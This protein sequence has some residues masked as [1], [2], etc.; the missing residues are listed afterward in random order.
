M[1][2]DLNNSVQDEQFGENTKNVKK[3]TLNEASGES[4]EAAAKKDE[5]LLEEENQLINSDE[6]VQKTK[7]AVTKKT[8]ASDKKLSEEEIPADSK[9]KADSDKDEVDS[10]EKELVESDDANAGADSSSQNTIEEINYSLLSKSDL[11]K[12]LDELVNGPKVNKISKEVEEIKAQF[13]K[14]HKAD[15][16]EKKKHFLESGGNETDF[17]PGINEDEL[18]L[19]EILNKYKD[20]RYQ[21]EQIHESEKVENLKKKYEIIEKIKELVHN[22]ESINKTFK[23]FSDLQKEWH[24]VG[25]VPQKDLKTLWENYNYHVEKFYDYIKI[26][27]ELRD[28][29]LKKNLEAKIV[30][31]E[32][33]EELILETN[34]VNAFHSLQKLHDQ[35]REI[36]PVDKEQR[37]EI[38]DRFKEATSKINKKHH[39]YYQDLKDQQKKNLESKIILC[40]KVEEILAENI[41]EHSLWVKKTKEILE[42]QNVWKTIGFAPKKDNNKVYARF[43]SAC[44]T[45][46]EKKRKF[47]SENMSNQTDNLNKKL[48]LCESAE[49][50]KDSE[51]WK[52]TADQ[53]IEIQKE[54]KKIGPVPRKQSDEVWKRFRAAC[55]HF[56]NKRSEFYANS[57]KNY[58]NNLKEKE[59]LIDEINAYIP[60]DNQKVNLNELKDFQRRWTEIGFVPINA[61]EEIS[62]KYREAIDRQFDKLDLDDHKKNM[63]KFKN[64]LEN[65]VQKPRS[66]NKLRFEREKMMTRLQQ[67]KSDISVWE[68]NI[69]FFANTKKADIMVREFQKKIQDAHDQ[70]KLL[71][72]KISVLD[73]T[74]PDI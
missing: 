7:K 47:Y 73:D 1:E 29:D 53:L 19:K 15:I 63:L 67:L 48:K 59:K 72:N 65:I 8:K 3:K 70:I 52:A 14:K 60:V 71:E 27:K 32:K 57:D 21:Q 18:M 54:W 36:G 30:I 56:F 50:L 9:V 40:E 20:I 55:D 16:H 5:A 17:S 64:K 10:V 41:N 37:T 74:A 6:P 24:D 22:D 23:D 58:E 61:K 51:D 69:G 42:L 44:D 31:C 28:L 2:N 68:N 34:I 26:N 39:D 66:D 25:L 49:K 33:A 38:W 35:W 45:F 43:R 4:L 46:F 12:V 13:Y 11:V 62:Q